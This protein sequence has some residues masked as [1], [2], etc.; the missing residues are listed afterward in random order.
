MPLA[1]RYL[2]AQEDVDRK[3]AALQQ[4]ED[5][6]SATF[7]RILDLLAE[8]SYVEDDAVTEEGQRL[9]RIHH[10]NDLLVAQCL[11]RNIWA[12]LD[13][14]ELAGVVSLCSFENRRE[15]TDGE[16]HTASEAMQQAMDNTQ[17]LWVELQS[18]ERRHGLEVSQAPDPHFALAMHQWT[19]GAPLEYCLAAAHQAGA[20][21]SPG[22]F[23][24]ACRQVIDL[25]NQVKV[26]AYDADTKSKA[27]QAV[28]AISRG[29]V[30]A[31]A[32]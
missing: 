15:L 8:M 24:R 12:D 10:H 4:R 19:A 3:R 9:A 5:T 32:L 29:V 26:T 14:A 27:H 11:R 21:L 25:L 30:A 31:A 23:V 1:D 20:D 2:R 13:P 22:D 17:R 6:L 7:D 28:T 18:D 16:I